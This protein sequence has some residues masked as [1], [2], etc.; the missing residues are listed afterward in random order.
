MV[1]PADG[2]QSAL[3]AAWRVPSA[4]PFPQKRATTNYCSPEYGTADESRRIRTTFGR[5]VQ[6][7]GPTN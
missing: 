6:D 7:D 2:T 3:A 5:I 1:S 4:G